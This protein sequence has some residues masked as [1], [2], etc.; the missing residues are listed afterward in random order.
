MSG[1]GYPGHG[2][3]IQRGGV[4]VVSGRRVFGTSTTS[5]V[6]ASRADS[7]APSSTSYGDTGNRFGSTSNPWGLRDP[8]SKRKKRVAK[9]KVYAAEASEVD[10][11][12]DLRVCDN[13]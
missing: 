1:F 4:G 6:H 5:Q 13:M 12:R 2:S 8:E 3:D 10:Q 9:Y 11:F 7:T